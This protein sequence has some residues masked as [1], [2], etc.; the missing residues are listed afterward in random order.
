MT[1]DIGSIIEDQ[2][3]KLLEQNVDRP[4]IDAAEGAKMQSALWRTVED[5]GIPLAM[6]SEAQGGIGLNADETFKL[7]SL[8]AYHALPLP[9]GETITVAGLLDRALEGP[10]TFASV[11]DGRADRVSFGADAAHLL[12]ADETGW[13]LVPADAIVA[14]RG[15]NL[16]EEARDELELVL[17]QGESV[18]VPDWLTSDGIE[19]VGALL[20]AAQMRG[21]MKRAVDMS[22]AHARDRSQFGRPIAKF[23]AV[24]HMLA[25]AAGQLVSAGALVDNAAEV[26]GHEDFAFRSALAKSRAGGAAGKVAEVA[27]QVHAAMGFTRDHDLHLYTRRLWSWREEFGSEAVWQERIGREIC[28]NGGTSLWPKIVSATKGNSK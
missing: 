19:A 24:Q 12:C 8:A 5:A 27:H 22:L 28:A 21:A 14:R 25:D 10:A 7:I 1:E 6:V 17:S 26:W 15:T 13:T 16:A 9:L 18:V 23:Q 2:F 4:I 11:V 20:R 3:T